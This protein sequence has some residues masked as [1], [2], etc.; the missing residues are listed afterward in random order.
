[1]TNRFILLTILLTINFTAY[2]NITFTDLA[3]RTVTL[4]KPAQKVLLG[5]GRFI[6]ALGTLGVK[7]PVDRIAG[8]MGEFR[9]FDPAGFAAFKI[10]YP[11]IEDVPTFGR[12]TED[13]ASIEKMLLLKPDA[14]IFGLNGHGP[15]ARAEHIIKRLEA[16]NIPVIF[17]DFRQD[18]I[19]NTTRSM[20]ILGQVLGEEAAAKKFVT[21]YNHKIATIKDK[22]KK[23]DSN[24]YPSVLIELRAA[25]SAEC[26]LSV[27]RG[28]FADMIELAGGRSIAK[29]LLPGAVGKLSYE[30]IIANG[31]DIYIGTATGHKTQGPLAAGVSVNQQ[32]AEDSLQQLIRQRKFD[33]FAAI[34]KGNAYSLWHHFYNSPLNL[35]AIESM[36]KWFH[37]TVFSELNPE[38][39]LQTLLSGFGDVDLTGTYAVRIKIKDKQ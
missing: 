31:F 15:S 19:K 36:A 10:A 26:C 39:T 34:Q 35:Y 1:M 17:I 5:E 25:I 32:L 4:E 24:N 11:H 9:L 23:I 18:P 16:A 8:M 27:G 29:G 21:L 28:L 20:E 3:G 38:A 33:K 22:A 12:T 7:K 13:S 30:H 14:A 37:P 2:A 6:A